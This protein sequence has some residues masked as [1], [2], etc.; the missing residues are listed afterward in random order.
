MSVKPA[1]DD[2]GVV[3]FVRLRCKTLMLSLGFQYSMLDLICD[4][5]YNNMI[6]ILYMSVLSLASVRLSKL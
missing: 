4:V 1:I 2:F 6:R 3:F 5:D